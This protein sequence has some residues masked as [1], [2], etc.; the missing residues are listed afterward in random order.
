MKFTPTSFV[1][2][3]LALT[4]LACTG[5]GGSGSAEDPVRARRYLVWNLLHAPGPTI[6]VF[7]ENEQLIG[8][9]S[10]TAIEDSAVGLVSARSIQYNGTSQFAAR[11]TNSTTGATLLE[12]SVFQNSSDRQL[13][14][15]YGPANAAKVICMPHET[16]RQNE[17]FRNQIIFAHL[18][19]PADEPGFPS[20]V[21]V[22]VRVDGT[23]TLNASTKVLSLVSYTP[24]R[25]L[26]QLKLVN[27]NFS[28]GINY[29]VVVTRAGEFTPL[30]TLDQTFTN[31]HH[32]FYA[33]SLNDG[34]PVMW[35][36]SSVY[37]AP[38]P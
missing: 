23:T 5:G 4:I 36:Y 20:Q 30:L 6:N 2:A 14:T 31:G 18:L 1:A 10:G 27:E 29:E 9:T 38:A 33:L 32:Y 3:A 37:G 17:G 12:E 21:D 26:D 25:P 35:Q 7:R 16:S 13:F 28:D 22:H 8:Q 11:V 24:S 15:V 19:D 34:N